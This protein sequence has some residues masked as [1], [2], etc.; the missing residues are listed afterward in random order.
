MKT[1]YRIGLGYENYNGVD[2]DVDARFE[3]IAKE[4]GGECG[5][6]VLGGGVRDMAFYF[7][8]IAQ[9]K[10]FRNRVNRVK[11]VDGLWVDDQATV[12]L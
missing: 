10:R 4:C 12:W 8:D 2:P 1:D 11:T 7:G 5:G 6:S 3:K 9:V